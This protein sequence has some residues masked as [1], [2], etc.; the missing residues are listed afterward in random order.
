MSADPYA[1]FD[2]AYLLGAL[3]P[4]QRVAFETHLT[5]CPRCQRNVAEIAGVPPLLAG[6]AE[7]ALGEPPDSALEPVPDTLL[8]GLLRAAGRERTRRRWLTSG[9]G[10]VAAASLTAV[11]VTALPPSG[12]AAPAPRAMTALVASQVDATVA[13]RATE[14]G[15]EIELTCWYRSDAAVPPGYQYELVAYDAD[16]DA[17]D[18]GSWQLDPGR[19][20]AFTGG[21]ALAPPQISKVQ[22]IRPDGAAILTLAG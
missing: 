18:V 1:H 21:V 2:A 11:L 19:K 3:E 5:T 7:S 13:L 22:I 15:T 12:P 8:T 4:A 17:Y 6:L 14:W 16:G 20:V 9:L 10:L